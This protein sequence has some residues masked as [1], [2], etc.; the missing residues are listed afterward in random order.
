MTQPCNYVNF[1]EM[2]QAAV[3]MMSFDAGNKCVMGLLWWGG[4]CL[5]SLQKQ[6]VPHFFWSLPDFK[7]YSNSL[8]GSFLRISFIS[9][10]LLSISASNAS[11]LF[12]FFS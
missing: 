1:V 8:L 5:E 9:V 12:S 11:A 7:K 6:L 3:D 10:T 2:V 4:H